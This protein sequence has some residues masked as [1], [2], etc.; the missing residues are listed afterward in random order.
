MKKEKNNNV[1]TIFSITH[2]SCIETFL[3]GLL[4]INN[5]PKGIHYHDP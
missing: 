5:C 4:T 2:K 1:L 3:N